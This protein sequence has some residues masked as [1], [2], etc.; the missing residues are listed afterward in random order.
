MGVGGIPEVIDSPAVGAL[1]PA[2][3]IDAFIAAIERLIENPSHRSALGRAARL[4]AARKFSADAI[5]PQ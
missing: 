5:V 3:E 2:G 4:A 1:V